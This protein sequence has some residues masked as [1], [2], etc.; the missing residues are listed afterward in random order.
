MSVVAILGAGTLGGALAH[1]LAERNKV[2]EVRLI[3]PTRNIAT[4]KALDI[5][6]A[7]PLSRCATRIVTGGIDAVV[8]ATVI[9]VADPANRPNNKW[10]K[11][12]ALNLLAEVAQLA[13]FAPIVCAG[14][15][16]G[17]LIA[18]AVHQLGINRKRIFG[19]AP[20][21]MVSGLRAL[22]ALE[23]DV[24][25]RDV[26][27]HIIGAPPLHTVVP[28]SSA[29]ICGYQL[30]K[31][32]SANQLKKLR[33]C[34]DKL[35]PPGPYTLAS[36]TTLV[37]ETLTLGS[38]KRAFTCFIASESHAATHALAAYATLGTTGISAVIEPRLTQIE[39]VQLETAVSKI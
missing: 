7:T 5:Q 27:I 13:N 8:G 29:T 16:D 11:E 18:S 36:A 2:G 37:V 20:A 31:S 14:T 28:W 34:V 23:A 32:L 21:A 30:E 15:S 17:P 12:A 9:V 35:W 39:R 25:P 3:D 1:K 19:T 4:A 26:T 22:V 38:L 24:S 10:P 6:Q 33:S